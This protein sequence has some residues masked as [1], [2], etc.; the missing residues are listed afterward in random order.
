MV[1][2]VVGPYVAVG[3]IDVHRSIQ[4]KHT[5]QLN[6]TTARS[7]LT[8]A[9]KVLQTDVFEL[10]PRITPLTFRRFVVDGVRRRCASRL[11]PQA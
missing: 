8:E 10:P 7:C 6:I 4:E 2:T 11:F 3:S 9:A 1:D 5:E